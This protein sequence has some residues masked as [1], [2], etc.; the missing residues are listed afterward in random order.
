MKNIAI[1]L[2]LVFALISCGEMKKSENQD[3]RKQILNK[4]FDNAQVQ[5]IGIVELEHPILGGIKE[6]V[7][8]KGKEKDKFLSELDRLNK[9]GDYNCKSSHMV[10]INFASDT[11]RLKVCGSMVSNHQNDQ[12]FELPDKKSII[13]KYLQL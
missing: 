4:E 3:V 9:V 5:S 6:V 7:R 11:L 1:Y 10:Q 13:E 12:Y 2:F 8:L